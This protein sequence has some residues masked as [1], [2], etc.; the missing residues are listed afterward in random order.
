MKQQ[1]KTT[2]KELNEKDISNIPDKEFKVM[3]IKILTRREK[4]EGSQ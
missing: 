4:S 1:D 3:V 2:T